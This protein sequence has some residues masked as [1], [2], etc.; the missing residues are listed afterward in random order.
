MSAEKITTQEKMRPYLYQLEKGKARL[1]VFLDKEKTPAGSM[2]LASVL[3]R[4]TRE[5]IIDELIPF[6]KNK[7]IAKAQRVLLRG[8]IDGCSLTFACR[9]L[10]PLDY[11]G[12]PAHALSYP[13]Q[14]SYNQLR[15]YFRV[16][17]KG[18]RNSVQLLD[19]G[20][21]QQPLAEGI[22]FDISKGGVAVEFA[23]AQLHIPQDQPL[24]LR[25]EFSDEDI[26]ESAGERG[27]RLR[28]S[29]PVQ[30]K[31]EL[32]IPAGRPGGVPNKRV[33]FM[34]TDINMNSHE[35]VVM[36]KVVFAIQLRTLRNK[37]N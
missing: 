7:D 25:L 1:E 2:L 24:L 4:K 35:M 33:G 29:I 14:L 27:Q 30:A 36:G 23:D 28:F 10:R 5:L 26:I 34:F 20:E 32:P 15:E 37:A 18:V 22:L 13:E 6:S 11:Q 9:Y 3:E 31:A 19:T 12:S 8:K 17:A 16:S 21:E